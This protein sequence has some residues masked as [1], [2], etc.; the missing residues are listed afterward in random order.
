MSA[1]TATIRGLVLALGIS[2]GSATVRADDPHAGHPPVPANGPEAAAARVREAFAKGDT[3]AVR[4]VAAGRS[5]SPYAVADEL[6]GDVLAAAPGAHAAER[7]RTFGA[8]AEGNPVAAGLPALVDRWLSLTA[9]ELA[10]ERRL[11]DAAGRQL[12]ATLAQDFGESVRIGESAL[13]D[14]RAAPWSFSAFRVFVDFAQANQRLGR[15]KVAEDAFADAARTAASAGHLAASARAELD[16]ATLAEGRGDVALA[17]ERALRSQER[18][19]GV[20]SGEAL[21]AQI[22][23]ARMLSSVGRLD[24]A[25]IVAKD[26]L[27][28]AQAR[29]D[30]DL[31]AQAWSSLASVETALG[32]DQKADFAW[33]HE[34]ALAQRSGSRQRILS[35]MTNR[36]VRLARVRRDADA[37]DAF[38]QTLA[39]LAEKPYPRGESVAER[40][41][42]NLYGRL[43]RSDV[44]LEHARRALAAA[45]RSGSADLVLEAR[46]VLARALGANHRREEAL[47]MHRALI[48]A[49]AAAGDRIGAA[50]ARTNAAWELAA[51]HRV[52]EAIP[53]QEKALAEFEA[54]GERKAAEAARGQLA[55]YFEVE[56]GFAKAMALATAVLEEQAKLDPRSRAGLLARRVVARVLLRTGRL[57]ESIEAAR[58]LVRVEGDV[59][60][61]LDEEDA[62]GVREN[63]RASCEVGLRAALELA[64]KDPAAAPR[65]ASAAFEFA[66]AARG[67]LLAEGL[68]NASGL[69]TA[70]L[71]SELVAAEAESRRALEASRRLALGAAPA[72]GG[73]A[74]APRSAVEPMAEA[75]ARRDEV[76]LRIQRNSRRA[77]TWVVPPPPDETALRAALDERTAFVTY[78]AL[79]D[80]TLADLPPRAVAIVVRRSGTTLVEL[81]R[82]GELGEAVDEFL[83]LAATPG[84]DDTPAAKRL[85]DALARPVERALEGASRLVLVP[86]GTLSFLPF[87][88]L[89]RVDGGRRE[90]LVERFEVSYA[91]SASVWLSLRASGAPTGERVLAVGDPAQA[92][93]PRGQGAARSPTAPSLPASALEA[94]DVARAFPSGGRT[95]LVGDAATVEGVEAATKAPGARYRVLHF[96]C[97]GVIDPSRARGTGL[98]LAH[99]EVLDVDRLARWRVPADVAVLSACESGRGKL[100]RGEGVFGLPRAFF[101]AG[102][103]RVV[104]SQ[105]VVYD[106]T[107]RPFMKRFYDGYV[108]GGLTA[109]AALR[110]AK[111]AALAEGGVAAH[112]SAWAAF[113]LWGAGD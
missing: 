71:P 41:L 9:D 85:Y 88:A 2:G 14:A 101:L 32:D 29:A 98:L 18:L 103:P 1:R 108:A 26:A 90:R 75:W 79:D 76:V 93:V 61:G 8:G 113:V 22:V 109:A 83:R 30:E 24:R 57:T 27:A 81:P 104:V 87:E 111:R 38:E 12:R 56:G 106:R 46:G 42:A 58:A 77:A 89:L 86:D 5:P 47:A 21:R 63:V 95:L 6:F 33:A 80:R 40:E 68:A 44:A 97:H 7:L 19:E 55:D 17:L 25:L 39:R 96:A 31:E 64:T 107:T 84:T 102:V 94:E 51:L 105:W 37:I 78:L 100:A 10:R 23:V 13:V 60:R 69:L 62:I 43:G 92:D 45:E 20:G 112:P 16:A 28:K 66:E 72:V 50:L 67:A 49:H 48:D 73:A 70:D 36:A 4:R 53:E 3:E 11:R 15:L 54:A 82:A 35:S 52:D 91:P 110:A 99:G 65:A 59:G 34:A 74:D